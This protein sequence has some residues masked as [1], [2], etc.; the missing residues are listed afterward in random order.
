MHA[1]MWIGHV[2]TK[3]WLIFSNFHANVLCF[4][5]KVTEYNKY[6]APLTTETWLD[7]LCDRPRMCKLCSHTVHVC[8]L[9][10]AG[11]IGLIKQKSVN[12][13]KKWVWQSNTLLKVVKAKMYVDNW[14]SVKAFL[15]I[16]FFS[17]DAHIFLKSDDLPILSLQFIQTKQSFS[18]LTSSVFMLDISSRTN[19]F[20]CFRVL[21]RPLL[22]FTSRVCYFKFCCNHFVFSV[23]RLLVFL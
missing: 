12:H 22:S 11:L 14:L 16:L 3:S 13:T 4:N 18:H 2:C 1:N 9:S 20:R 6:S 19:L 15:S 10:L 5:N 7:L 8:P 23:V 17:L 21:W